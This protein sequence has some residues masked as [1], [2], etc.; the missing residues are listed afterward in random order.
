MDVEESDHVLAPIETPIRNV[1]ND[2]QPTLTTN[3]KAKA[4][5]KAKKPQKEEKEEIQKPQLYNLES[6]LLIRD[7]CQT[8]LQIVYGEQVYSFEIQVFQKPIEKTNHS[9]I[10]FYKSKDNYSIKE[11]VL[12]LWGLRKGS[13]ELMKRF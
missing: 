5:A 13:I 1:K 12:S 8:F 4:K 9:K 7:P 10:L 2:Q 3:G 11:T 6:L